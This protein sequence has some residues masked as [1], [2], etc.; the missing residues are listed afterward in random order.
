MVRGNGYDHN[1]VL[2]GSGLRRVA[3]LTAADTGR[4]MDVI[5]D[6][7]GVQIYSANFL[8][9]E[10]LPLRGNRPQEM[11]AAI[12][13]ETQHFPDSPNKPQFPSVVLRPGEIYDTTTI[14]RFSTF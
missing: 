11:R 2:N 5:T 1:F 14:Y 12:C 4:R 7:P 6:Q 9:D 10:T 3:T 13:L 8:T